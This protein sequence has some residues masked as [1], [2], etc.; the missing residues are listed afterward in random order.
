MFGGGEEGSENG[1]D[2]DEDE[3]DAEDGAEISFCEDGE[4][5]NDCV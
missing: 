4:D 1:E 5:A 3:P 2:D